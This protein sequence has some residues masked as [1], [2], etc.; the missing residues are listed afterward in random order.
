MVNQL[1]QD[2]HA[3]GENR[4]QVSRFLVVGSLS[5]A[6][7]FAFYLLLAGPLG[8]DA[9]LAKG[10]SY[11]A[12]TV[13]GFFGNKYWTFGSKRR[14][15]SEPIA[16]GILYAITLAV[17]I[18]VNAS[19][20]VLFGPLFKLPAFVLAT[21]TTMVLN[22]LGL[23]LVTFRAG[24]RERIDE[25]SG[26]PTAPAPSTRRAAASKLTSPLHELTHG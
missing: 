11:L 9:H 20:L 1:W 24:I 14:S 6:T 17:N 26:Q 15:L 22:F 8:T 4:R 21:G 3:G 19:V 23:R 12:G 25:R 18:A 10:V 2:G 16:Y 13:V 7:D 5:V